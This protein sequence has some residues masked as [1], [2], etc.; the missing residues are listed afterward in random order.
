[1]RFNLNTINYF[2]HYKDN[3]DR[4]DFIEYIEQIDIQTMLINTYLNWNCLGVIVSF[5][6]Q[7]IKTHFLLRSPFISHGSSLLEYLFHCSNCY[8]F[9]ISV[10]SFEHVASFERAN[11]DIHEY[12]KL[13]ANFFNTNHICRSIIDL[14]S[15]FAS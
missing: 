13:F 4:G 10:P 2:T 1:M 8:Y 9:L 6:S 15:F 14:R 5:R 3:Y 7:S 12:R 11:A